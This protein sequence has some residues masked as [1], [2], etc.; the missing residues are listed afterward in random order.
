MHIYIYIH[1]WWGWQRGGGNTWNYESKYM[2]YSNVRKEITIEIIIMLVRILFFIQL[3]KHIM[4]I[5]KIT[6]I[7][8]SQNEWFLHST[9]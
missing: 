5:F 1:F 9:V 4:A 2:H 7:G 6:I 3:N 8:T